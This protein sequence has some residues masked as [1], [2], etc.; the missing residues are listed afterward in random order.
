MDSEKPEEVALRGGL[1]EEV[2]LWLRAFK[3]RRG[4]NWVGGRWHLNRRRGESGQER[5]WA[6]EWDESSRMRMR[7]LM[8]EEGSCILRQWNAHVSVKG[9][10]LETLW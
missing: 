3:K 5:G 10:G 4:E 8:R 2:T 6:R 7:R 9:L 1:E